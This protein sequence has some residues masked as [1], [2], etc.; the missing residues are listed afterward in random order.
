MIISS[1]Q[2]PK[3]KQLAVWRKGRERV[4]DGVMLIEGYEELSL[5]ARGG[6]VL[7][8][9][10][11]C[12]ELMGEGQRSL[13]DRVGQAE[14]YELSRP[15]FEKVAYR[16]G[17]DG[18]LA[19]ADAPRRRLADVKLRAA[20]LVL[21]IEGVEKPGNI[22][23]MLRTADAAG[24]DAVVI[25]DAPTD[26]GNPNIVRSSKGTLFSVPVVEAGRDETVA[27][28]RKHN[29]QLLAATPAAEKVYT[30]VDMTGGV[31]VA[32]G[33]EKPGLTDELMQQADL[34]LRIPMAGKIDSLNVATSAALLLF[35]AVRQR[36]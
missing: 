23:A 6:V 24:V 29:I 33:A 4:T 3:I 12:P 22:G 21:V 17:P 7:R 19:V 36:G 35:E 9:V 5:A 27:W 2:N 20:P 16:E 25:I 14:V 15:V 34:R 31:A 18:W 8:E 30:A 13:L 28:L 11:H 32:V 10:Y 26:L 1:F